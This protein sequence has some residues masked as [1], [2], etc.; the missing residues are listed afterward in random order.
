MLWKVESSTQAKD[1]SMK[2]FLLCLMIFTIPSLVFA[3]E[4]DYKIGPFLQ[5]KIS[6]SQT[7]QKTMLFQQQDSS[8]SL[9]EGES[10]D[11][12]KIIVVMDRHHLSDLP[13]SI[14]EELE[15]KVTECG[16]YVGDHAYNKVQVFIPVGKIKK[17]AEWEKIRLIK[18]PTPPGKMGGNVLSEGL[19]IGNIN[20]WHDY[21]FTGNGVRV[22]VLDGGFSGYNGLIGSELPENTKA[23]Y[24][25][26]SSDFYS[27]EHGT[28][29]AEII[30]DVAPG[31]ALYL[32]NAADVDVEY[33][34][35]VNWLKQQN[36]DII[37]S[38]YGLNLLYACKLMY[39]LLNSNYFST[40]YWIFQAQEISR[41]EEQINH[42][43]SHTVSS[44]IT[45]AQA[46]N[47]N[48]RQR[49]KGTF[50][51]TDNDEAH[52]FSNGSNY[53]ELV[54]PAN[55]EYGKDVYVVMLWGEDTDFI[56]YDDYDLEIVDGYDNTVAYS[57]INQSSVPIGM[58]ACRFSAIPG[59]NYYIRSVRYR[60]TIQEIMLLV[61][62]DDF[63]GL[64]EYSPEKTV[65][66]GTPCANP[67]VISVGAVPYYD[68]YSIEYF[69]GQG[70]GENGIIKPDLVAPDAVSTV[71]YGDPFY[72]TSAAA[73]HVAGISALVKQ[74]YPSY[75]PQQ[76]KSYLESNALDLGASGKDN[77]YGSGLVQLPDIINCIFDISPAIGSFSSDGG[78]STVFV[79]TS[80]SSCAWSI[81]NN[82]SWVSLSP[83][84]GTGSGSV[85]LVVNPNDGSPRNGSITIADHIFNI[86]QE[87]LA[88]NN[89]DTHLSQ[90]E[91]SQLY[92]AIFGRAS[93]GSGNVYWQTQPDMTT[94]ADTMLETQAAKEYFGTNFET[95]QAFIEHIYWNTLN[96]SFADDPDGISYWTDMLNTGTTRGA[97]VVAIIRAIHN[98]APGGPSYDP[99]DS[100]TTAAYEQFMNRVEVSNYMADTISDL[101]DDWETS[102]SFSHGLIV[103]DDPE[104][105][106]SAMTCV[107]GFADASVLSDSCGT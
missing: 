65:L 50:N 103:T 1:I 106:L 46:A 43:V 90:T 23:V 74:K 6:P 73:P 80:S 58:E 72:G 31:T 62:M 105:V 21:G 30:H 55:F 42:T 77:V 45:W 71:S 93:E 57:I 2:K 37:S 33:V 63:A 85:T 25:G 53:N 84:S 17:L 11:F 19:S 14:I 101:P 16:G 35:A 4:V 40:N 99:D 89:S 107:D 52:N 92:V 44:G 83:N 82:L 81:S 24:T 13:R 86:N 88:N 27:T 94:A 7:E 18:L 47:N 104:T 8:G 100:L 95:N 32:V 28:A 39:E 41:M 87:G 48:G 97:A 20:N 49:W 9:V 61:G 59:R 91:V 5:K 79:T 56:T 29:C 66:L 75:S 10:E 12:I 36:V 64:K 69:S 68:P 102:T 15:T 78:T 98:Y 60:A 22:G 76:I 54:L 70:P 34:S 26:S 3:N 96:K 67:D 51:D 38:S